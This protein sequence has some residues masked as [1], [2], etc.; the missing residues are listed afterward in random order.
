MNACTV[1]ILLWGLWN[2]VCSWSSRKGQFV[3]S[4]L[5]LHP[6]LPVMADHTL[7]VLSSEPLTIRSPLNCR[8]VITWSSWP[9]STYGQFDRFHDP[10][11][12]RLHI[13]YARQSWRAC[14]S[15]PWVPACPPSSSWSQCDVVWC[16]PISMGWLQHLVVHTLCYGMT[17]TLIYLRN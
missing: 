15:L 13:R 9:F 3:K 12:P 16:R 6:T 5:P 2:W 4:T 14:K 8:Q 10:H 11:S 7:S 17:H 1:F